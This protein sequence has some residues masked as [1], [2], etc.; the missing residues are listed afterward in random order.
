MEATLYRPNAGIIIF[1]KQ[2]K[3]LWCKRRTGDGWQ[4]PQGGI[5]E[6]ELPEEAIFRETYEEVGLDESKIRILKE[7]ERWVN[8]DVPRDKIP[9]YFS[10]KNRKFKGQTQKW[11]LAE[12]KCD[13]SK[14]NLNSSSPAEFDDWIWT[15]YWYPLGATVTFKSEAYRRALIDMMPTYSSFLKRLSG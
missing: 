1:N 6:G 14:I 12:L 9:R 13:E 4:F 5:D 11:F 3:L 2:G 7:N 15:K 10:F 8:Y